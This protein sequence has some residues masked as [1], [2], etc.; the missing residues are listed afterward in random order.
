MCDNAIMPYQETINLFYKSMDFYGLRIVGIAT[1][2]AP[3]SCSNTL[4]PPSPHPLKYYSFYFR[5]C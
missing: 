3:A 4:C 1:P 5:K 2:T